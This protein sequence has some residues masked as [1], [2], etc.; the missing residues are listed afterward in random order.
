MYYSVPEFIGDHLNPWITFASIAGIALS[1][2]LVVSLARMWRGTRP[3][4]PPSGDL[5]GFSAERYQVMERL[6]S[7]RD[8]QFLA[9]QPGYKPEMHAQW[10]H[11]SLR[12]FRLYLNELT[13]DFH[14]LHAEARRMVV[15]SRTASPE[16]AAILLRQ[17]VAFFQARL[18]LEWR[19]RLFQLGASNVEVASILNLVKS[20]QLDLSRIVPQTTTA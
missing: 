3:S 19:L 18:Q 15:E 16:F 7:L 4:G 14:A 2:G 10:K 6:L 5:A 13:L 12:V 9:S 8:L 17:N 20:M 11:E 1:A